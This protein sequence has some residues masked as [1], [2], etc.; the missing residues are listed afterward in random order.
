M[1]DTSTPST[2]ASETFECANCGEE[3]PNAER[4]AVAFE[5]WCTHCVEHY[6]LPEED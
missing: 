4:D 5:V 2:N 6:D 3:K 1:S